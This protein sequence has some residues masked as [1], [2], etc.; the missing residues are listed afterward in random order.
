MFANLIRKAFAVAK[1]ALPHSQLICLRFGGRNALADYW[2]ASVAVRIRI[3]ICNR[4]AATA[5]HSERQESETR[6]DFDKQLRVPRQG[7]QPTL[8]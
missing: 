7:Q 5:V 3:R 1:A 2:G 6:P 4:I 8:M